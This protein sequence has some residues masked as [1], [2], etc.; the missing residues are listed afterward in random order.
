[1]ENSKGCVIIIGVCILLAL[2][3]SSLD[4]AIAFLSEYWIINILLIPLIWYIAIQL[5][6]KNKL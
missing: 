3:I 1:M 2:I 6:K 4:G 5:N